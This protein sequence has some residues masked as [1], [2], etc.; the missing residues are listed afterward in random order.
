MANN[1][2][3]P[4]KNWFG[5]KRDQFGDNWLDRIAAKDIQNNRLRILQD[6]ARG[7]FDCN[8]TDLKDFCDNRVISQIIKY[9]DIRVSEFSEIVN[10]LATLINS[11]NVTPNTHLVFDRC[12]NVLLIYRNI[13]ESL[14]AFIVTY[15]ITIFIN[16]MQNMRNYRDFIDINRALYQ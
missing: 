11:G 10:G 12:N 5:Q 9:A 6:I 3:Q 1:N 15:D 14:E 7:N 4:R 13:K 8:S 16:M 2:R